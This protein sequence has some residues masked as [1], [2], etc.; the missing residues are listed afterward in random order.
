MISIINAVQPNIENECILF[1]IFLRRQN[2]FKHTQSLLAFIK[3]FRF[4]YKAENSTLP[5]QR[6]TTIKM[7]LRLIHFKIPS[8]F[9]LNYENLMTDCIT[10]KSNGGVM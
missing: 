7:I 2:T 3:D 8:D 6:L 1:L 5:S 9:M 10:G 4:L